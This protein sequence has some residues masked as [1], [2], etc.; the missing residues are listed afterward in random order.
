MFLRGSVDRWAWYEDVFPPLDF[1]VYAL[2]RDG[3]QVAPF[4]QHADGDGMPRELG[5]DADVWRHWI[6]AMI[7][8]RALLSQAVAALAEGWRAESRAL[9]GGPAHALGQPS[10]ACPG[11]DALR[12]RLDE[13]WADY[14][15]IGNA[16]KRSMT[17][18]EEDGQRRGSAADQ[19]QRWQALMRF[20]DRLPTISVFLVAYP[21]P[22]VMPVPPTT[23]LIAPVGDPA[24]YT[25][26]VVTAAE[27]LAAA[28]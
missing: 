26:Q 9:G 5:L 27:S 8:Q 18:G 19:R 10:S 12:A 17:T 11:S 22:V 13:I 3:L 28:A 24:G 15:P 23:C 2:I 21:V 20:H 4:D 7:E 16:W 25:R 14:E 1:C 6:V